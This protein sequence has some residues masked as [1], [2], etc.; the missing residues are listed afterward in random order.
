MAF[1]CIYLMSGIMITYFKYSCNVY[2]TPVG[3]II[4]LQIKEIEA[5]RH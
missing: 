4:F 3:A 2:N 5:E 1:I